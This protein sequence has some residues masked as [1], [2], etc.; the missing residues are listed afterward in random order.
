M[1][2]SLNASTAVRTACSSFPFEV[3]SRSVS[4]REPN[5]S[6]GQA[7]GFASACMASVTP[8]TLMPVPMSADVSL[9]ENPCPDTSSV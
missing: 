7:Q 4:S 3:A 5:T 8:W 1:A 9:S 6:T 2:P